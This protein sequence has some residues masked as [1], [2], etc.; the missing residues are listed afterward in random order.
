MSFK[1]VFRFDRQEKTDKFICWSLCYNYSY[2][3]QQN[4]LFCFLTWEIKIYLN[5]KPYIFIFKILFFSSIFT[6]NFQKLILQ[7]IS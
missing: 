4:N 7:E 5:K 3:N 2:F 1:N 6:K